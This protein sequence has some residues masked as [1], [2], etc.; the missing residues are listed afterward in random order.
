MEGD[1]GWSSIEDIYRW[2]WN[3]KL[4]T[5]SP[6]GRSFIV[7][8]HSRQLLLQQQYGFKELYWQVQKTVSLNEYIDSWAIYPQ[9]WN[10][11]DYMASY[12]TAK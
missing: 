3:E 5:N 6:A 7:V 10:Y 1:E 4:C 12:K 2:R 11:T 8:S 9:Y